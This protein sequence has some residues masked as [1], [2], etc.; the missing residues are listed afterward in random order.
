MRRTQELQDALRGRSLSKAVGLD[1]L[2]YKLY[3][4][5]CDHNE[6]IRFVFTQ[7]FNV[8]TTLG[9]E[10]TKFLTHRMALF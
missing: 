8:M 3:R 2:E 7:L 5:I 4:I 10:P 9:A 1:G 6:D